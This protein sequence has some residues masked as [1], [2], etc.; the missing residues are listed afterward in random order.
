MRGV[1]RKTL[2]SSLCFAGA[3]A[4]SASW[5]G[6]CANGSADALDLLGIPLFSNFVGRS[7]TTGTTGST[8]TS[9]VFGSGGRTNVDPCAEALNR[10]FVR[11]S[12]RN[13]DQDDFIH[14]F[15]VLVAFVNG[16]TY[17]D[18]AVCSSDVALY[19]SFGYSEVPEGASVSFGSY[20]ITGP[21]LIYFHQSGGFRRGGSNTSATLASAISPAQGSN[22]TFDA[23]FNSAGAQVPVPNLIAFHNPGTGE[24]AALKISRSAPNPCDT[25]TVQISDSLCNQDAFYYVDDTDRLAGSSAL[26]VGSGRRVPSE[27]QG[28]SCECLGFS[29]PFQVLAPSSVT[30]A[31][32]RCNEFVRGGRIEYVFLRNDTNPPFPQLVWKVSDASGATVQ[33]FDSR[34]NLP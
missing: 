32:A 16:T 33:E 9:G 8:G 20:C 24:G 14:Y 19:T 5:S 10:K 6:G 7:T 1:I 26:G 23:F 27:I 12:M 13:A 11:I 2:A 4:L 29:T 15:L 18:G 21:A 28:T 34:A 30:A 22:P 3:V 17:P 31:S 25:A